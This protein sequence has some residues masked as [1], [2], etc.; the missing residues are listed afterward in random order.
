MTRAFV[1]VVPPEP[2]LAAVG[3]ALDGVRAAAPEGARWTVREQHHLT[4]QFLGNRVELDAVGAALHELA[5]A[6]ADVQLGGIGAF[7]SAR[8]GRVLWV[9]VSTGEAFLAQLA[10]AVGVLLAP[11]GYEPEARPY[12]PHCTLA[13]WKTPTDLRPIVDNEG[14]AVGDPWRATE[15]VLFESVLRPTGAQYVAREVVALAG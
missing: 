2:V 6:A 7:P 14:G 4:L 8:R 3:V 10:A 1:A 12:H 15:V 13:R 9:G 5:V 11:L